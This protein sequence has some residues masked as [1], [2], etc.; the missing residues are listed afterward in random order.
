MIFSLGTNSL[1]TGC[2]QWVE[3]QL[4]KALPSGVIKAL[5]QA[6]AGKADASQCQHR[7]S[8]L[9]TCTEDCFWSNTQ[10]SWTWTCWDNQALK[11][12]VT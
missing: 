2:S 10:S 5:W 12:L 1:E 8:D 7:V 11:S 3:K 6:T 4:M 9:E